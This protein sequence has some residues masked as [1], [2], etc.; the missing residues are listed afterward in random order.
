MSPDGRRGRDGGY[1]S[2][3]KLPATV[4]LG[5]GLAAGAL[6]VALLLVGCSSDGDDQLTVAAASSLRPAFGDP[7]ESDPGGGP[8]RFTFGGSDLLAGQIRQGAGID[9]I[10]AASTIQPDQLFEDGL[11]ERPVEFAGNRLVVGV[12]E[13]SGID[14]VEDIAGAGISL[15]IGDGSVP[16]GIY[17]REMISMLPPSTAEQIRANVR[18]QEQDATSITAKLTQGAADAGIVYETDVESASGQLK[19][20]EIPDRLQPR[21]AYSAA[22]VSD[23]DQEEQAEA[24]IDSLLSGER[25]GELRKA[26]LLPPP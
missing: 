18:S 7:G 25:A 8:V 16:I 1:G 9:V 22:V 17:A 10:A 26:G 6:V 12:P 13:D 2:A 20:V 23:S 19:A 15:V 14:S 3:A 24:F 21:I 5:V 4:L 11:V